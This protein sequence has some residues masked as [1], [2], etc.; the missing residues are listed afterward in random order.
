M[1]KSPPFFRAAVLGTAI[2]CLGVGMART[3]KV[4]EKGGDFGV[5]TFKRTSEVRLV[6]FATYGGVYSH[7]GR[8]IRHAWALQQDGKQK[9]PT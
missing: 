6:E 4:Y 9:C 8:L 1:E 3:H 2:L 5:L 7:N